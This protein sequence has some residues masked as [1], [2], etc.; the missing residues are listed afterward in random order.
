MHK[1]DSDLVSVSCPG[2]ANDNAN[3]RG[4]MFLVLDLD[5]IVSACVHVM[6]YLPMV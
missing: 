3:Q 6:L 4:R 5:S 2:Y 1:E